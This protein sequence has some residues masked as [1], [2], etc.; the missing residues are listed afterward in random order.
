MP[1]SPSTTRR[2]NRAALE[3]IQHVPFLHLLQLDVLEFAKTHPRWDGFYKSRSTRVAALTPGNHTL[4]VVLR[5]DGRSE[6]ERCIVFHAR[7]L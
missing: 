5:R 6:G 4:E 2:L 7:Y 3:D 1:K